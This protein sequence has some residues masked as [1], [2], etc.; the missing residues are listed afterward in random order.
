MYYTE[1]DNAQPMTIGD[2]FITLLVLA[3]PVVNIIMYLVWACGSSGNVNRKNF[4]TASILWVVILFGF[5]LVFGIFAGA[6]GLFVNAIGS[7]F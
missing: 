5:A 6:A 4:C 2:W 3:I 1:R 7:V